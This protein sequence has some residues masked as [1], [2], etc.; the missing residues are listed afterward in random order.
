[1]N[2]LLGMEDHFAKVADVYRAMRIT[3]EAP[4]LHIRDLL[5]GRA[6]VTAADIGCGAGRYDLLL[7]RHLHNLRLTCVD[8]SGEMLAQL[9]RYL[10]QNGIHDFETVNVRVEDMVLGDQ[11]LDCVVTFNAIHHFHFPLF[12]AKAGRAIKQDGQIFIYTRTPEQNAGS[13]WGKFFPGFSQKETRLYRL[14]EMEKWVSDTSGLKLI[15]VN[16]F[17]FPRT[18]SLERLVEQARNRHY[19]T[20]SLYEEA[21]FDQ[22]CQAFEE[23]VQAE[24]DNPAEVSWVDQNI[25]LQIGPTDN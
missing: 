11:S 9:T 24:F 4:I 5:A 20:F 2:E 8:L 14:E 3:D 16:T 7:F 18:S 6:D 25:L 13:V 17:R 15:E 23:A 22:A 21:A 12:L 1:M 10:K 19:S